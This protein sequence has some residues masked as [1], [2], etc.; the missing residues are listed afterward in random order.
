M[1]ET[2]NGFKEVSLKGVREFSTARTKELSPNIR[3]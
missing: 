3:Q 2:E 1:V